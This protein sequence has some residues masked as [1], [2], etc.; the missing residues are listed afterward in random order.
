MPQIHASLAISAKQ[1]AVSIGE[2]SDDDPFSKLVVFTEDGPV[3]WGHVSVRRT[4]VSIAAF[5]SATAGQD[6]FV[7]MSNEGD[8][9]FAEGKAPRE[10]IPGAG[11][12][13]DDADGYGS[14]TSIRRLDGQLWACGHGAQ[15]YVRAGPANW[16]RISDRTSPDLGDLR[17]LALA[18]SSK[19]LAACG[20]TSSVKRSVSAGEQA[21]MEA[22]RA[23]GDLRTYRSMIR[24]SRKAVSRPQ[25]CLFLLE[26]RVWRAADLPNNNYLH[27]VRCLPD[28]RFVAVGSAGTIVAGERPDQME[29]FS[30]PG[31][32]ERLVCV[33]MENDQIY[34]L[35]ETSVLLLASDL[36][37]V[38]TWPLPTDLGDPVGIDAVQGC[39]WFFGRNGMARRHA[40]TWQTVDIPPEFWQRP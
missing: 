33:R 17:F 12:L 22:A 18:K 27:D 2:L 32:S 36:S 1:A 20:F 29:D 37:F 25:G 14:M 39:V 40:G 10:K 8:V 34:V 26:N 28:G 4:L 7:A 15:I 3:V 31:L 16:Q 11:V 19:A 23:R 21:E 35:G 24:E 38:D 9:Y 6:V 5:A 13:S 30:V